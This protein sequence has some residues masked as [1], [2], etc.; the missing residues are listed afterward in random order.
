MAKLIE[1]QLTQYLLA[2]IGRASRLRGRECLPTKLGQALKLHLF[3]QQAT[4]AMGDLDFSFSRW[5]EFIHLL[6]ETV[7]NTKDYALFV[8]RKILQTAQ[9]HPII[10]LALSVTV[11]VGFLPVFLFSSFTMGSTGIVLF[12]VL[13]VQ[14]I[15][16]L[17]VFLG[18]FG[19]F[20][21]VIPISGVVVTSLYLVYHSYNYVA[22]LIASLIGRSFISSVFSALKISHLQRR[23]QELV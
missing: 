9:N 23:L 6:E 2:S 8:P 20:L 16:G 4:F 15:A 21:L 19:V 17:I 18:L 13:A 14:G 12:H 5:D 3:L 1:E 10:M 7:E 11:I 22:S